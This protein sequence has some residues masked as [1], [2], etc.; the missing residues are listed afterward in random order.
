MLERAL[1]VRAEADVDGLMS[2]SVNS[3]LDRLCNS[4]NSKN[5]DKQMLLPLPLRR[6]LLLLLACC[7][8]VSKCETAMA[9]PLCAMGPCFRHV[10]IP[11]CSLRRVY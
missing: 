2:V 4:N 9:P 8:C 11:P 1:L 5:D 10:L 7:L 6:L 3:Q